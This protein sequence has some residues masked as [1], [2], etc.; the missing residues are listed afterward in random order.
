M[1]REINVKYKGFDV[2]DEVYSV[3]FGKDFNKNVPYIA[4]KAKVCE[5]NVN[6]SKKDSG[7]EK[8]VVEY[9][10]KLDNTGLNGYR[11]ADNKGLFENEE[12]AMERVEELER[13]MDGDER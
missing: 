2:G 8:V 4:L 11:G 7:K 1:S 10:V 3:Q 12:E 9:V 5:V 13:E 6:Y